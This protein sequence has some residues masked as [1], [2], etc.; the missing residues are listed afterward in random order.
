MPNKLGP[1]LRPNLIRCPYCGDEYSDTYRSCPFCDG[2]DEDTKGAVEDEY[3][4]DEDEDYEEEEEA[5]TPVATKVRKPKKTVK[6]RK[7]RTSK[8]RG[9]GHFFAD[10]KSW[11]VLRILGTVAS[12]AVIVAAAWIVI[13][14]FSPMVI[15]G[16]SVDSS[17][18]TPSISADASEEDSDADATP[19]EDITPD[20][21]SD[22]STDSGVATGGAVSFTL[23]RSDFSMSYVGEVWDLSPSFYPSDTTGT[24][25]WVS[26]D[27]SCISVSDAGV[28]TGIA[29]GTVTITA[30][31]E[32]GYTQTCIVRGKMTSS[33]STTTTTTTSTGGL[34]ASHSDVTLSSLGESFTMT[35]SGASGTVVWNTGNSSVASVSGSGVITAT[36]SGST[37][38]TATVD[39]QS[40]SCTIR[41][42][43]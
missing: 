4:D 6:K 29:A 9:I 23:N 26:S 24:I 14:Y 17:T 8:S 38:V 33:S 43:F 32:N 36:G 35:I 7:R 21:S 5:S 40:F 12:M 27:P 37:T 20:E 19:S 28:V 13:A 2:G 15:R 18:P 11:S 30:T 22:A 39:G 31:M 34:S 1:G 10:S 25:T 42:S 3:E 41:C 16:D